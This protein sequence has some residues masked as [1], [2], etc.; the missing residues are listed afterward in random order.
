MISEPELQCNFEN[1]I[2]NWEQDT[3][4][5]F[6]WTRIQ[7]PTSTI[8]TGPMKDHTLGTAQGHYLY[9]E[10]SEPQIFQNSAVLL[11][12]ILNATDG[13]DCIF[14]FYYH[15]FGKH[16]YRL[17]IYQRVWSNSRGKLLWEIFGNQGNRWMRKLLNISS[18]QPFQVWIMGFIMCVWNGT[19]Y[20][21]SVKDHCI[22]ELKAS[23]IWSKLLWH[24]FI[25]SLRLY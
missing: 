2:C 15:M 24:T 11:S 10:S 5:I 22:L 16:I 3:E 6:D 13:K 4:D 18:R 9:I 21:S 1:G 20:L 8:N 7:G 23:G 12:P 19:G 25:I 17:A 14:R